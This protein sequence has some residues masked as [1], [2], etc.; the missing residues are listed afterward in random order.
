VF[1]IWACL[2]WKTGRYG[3]AF[4]VAAAVTQGLVT[5]TMIVRG[6]GDDEAVYAINGGIVLVL[7]LLSAICWIFQRR[8]AMSGE[9]PLTNP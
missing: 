4:G 1:L 6:I 5:R 3:A 9:R 8:R 7:M 2:V